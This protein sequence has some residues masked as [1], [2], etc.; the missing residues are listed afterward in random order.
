MHEALLVSEDIGRFYVH[1]K[2]EEKGH[3]GSED[4][5]DATIQGHEENTKN[6]KKK[7]K[8]RLIVTAN[9]INLNIILNRKTTKSRKQ[10]MGRKTRLSA[11]SLFIDISN[12]VGYLLPKQSL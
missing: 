9:N 7:K 4:C 2:K 5:V 8:K 10:N 6:S 3:N 1:E 11:V 12:F